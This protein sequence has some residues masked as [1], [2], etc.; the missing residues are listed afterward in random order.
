ME[1]V[2]S[3]L[4]VEDQ[5]LLAQAML[6]SV[7][8]GEGY[9]MGVCPSPV[10]S[11][12]DLFYPRTLSPQATST[13]TVSYSEAST[14]A[15]FFPPKSPIQGSPT[16]KKA[17]K[18]RCMSNGSMLSDG[19]I[20]TL[21]LRNVPRKYTQRMLLSAIQAGGFGNDIDFLYLPTDISS[22]RNLGYAF[23]NLLSAS[24]ATAFREQFHKRQLPGEI[25]K[26]GLSVSSALVQGFQ[27]NVDNVMRNASVHR[28]KNPEYL[29][30]VLNHYAHC[31]V[32]SQA[33]FQNDSM[34][35]LKPDLLKVNNLVC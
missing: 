1:A 35:S 33:V 23:V 6:E 4:S 7:I 31:L 18:N 13:P 17:K 20:T 11:F 27:N 28:I 16:I 15:S 2:F 3:E 34:C 8:L 26:G 10:A 19:Q 21:M 29:P 12:E 24:S 32:P 9:S 22:G 25:T 5:I 14:D 30:L